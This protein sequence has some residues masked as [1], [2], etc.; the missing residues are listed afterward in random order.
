MSVLH[1]VTVNGA[2]VV[3]ND[4]LCFKATTTQASKRWMAGKLQPGSSVGT[5]CCGA[6][7]HLC[8]SLCSVVAMASHAALVPSRGLVTEFQPP[9]VLPV[10]QH[11]KC[12]PAASVQPELDQLVGC[13]PRPE[14]RGRGHAAAVSPGHLPIL[15]L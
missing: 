7:R 13:G 8:C 15:P 2:S 10:S 9:T 1:N 6:E 4:D 5:A 11:A 14:Y 3:R 12:Q